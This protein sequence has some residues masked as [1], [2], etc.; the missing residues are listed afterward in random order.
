[1][2]VN[3]LP[4]NAAASVVALTFALALTGCGANVTEDP[5]A[6]GVNVQVTPGAPKVEPSRSLAFAAVVTGTISPAVTWSIQEGSAGGSISADGV[7]TA[8]GSTGV[9]RIVATSVADP[10]ATGTATVTVE[11]APTAPPPGTTWMTTANRTSGVAPLAVFFD[12]V[13]TV[14]EGF[15]SPYTWTTGVTQPA[16]LE[17]ATWVWDFGD[18]A[19]GTWTQTGNS[20]NAATGYTAAH[21][22][23][24]P[25]TYSVRLAVTGQDGV[26]RRYAQNVTVEPFTGTTYYVAAG[27]SDASDGL[28]PATPFRTFAKGVSMLTGPGRRLL[29]RRGDTFSTG[30]ASFT[31]TAS[32]PGI[33]GAYG[34]GERPVIDSSGTP[35][36]TNL[37]QFR[38]P[39]AKTTYIEDW[40]IMDLDFSGPGTATGGGIT[41]NVEWAARNF[42]FLR[43]RYRSMNVGLGWSDWT[44]IFQAP[45]DGMAV[46][47]CESA[48]AYQNGMYV[49]GRRLAM[50]GNDIHDVGYSHALRVWQAHK[51]VISNNRLWRPGGQRHA[52]KLHGNNKAVRVGGAYMPYGT[53]G[54]T[55][56]EPGRET[57]PETRWVTINDNLVKGG[58][59]SN[60]SISMGPQDSIS[61]ERVSHVVYERNHHL[62]GPA[63]MIDV[64]SSASQVMIRNNTF[65]ATLDGYYTGV[66][67][68][69]RGIEPVPTGYRVL[70]NTIY[71]GSANQDTV[72]FDFGAEVADATIRNNLLAFQ[73][74]GNVRASA[75]G[76]GPGWTFDHNLVTA[77][78][79][80][81]DA[82]AGDF[83]L[84]AGSPGV[85][86]GAALWDA[87]LDF[88]GQARPLGAGPDLG[89]IES[90]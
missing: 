13:E 67:V 74:G 9:F 8:P 2:F 62:G 33:I 45:R 5:V 55:A 89:A 58:D 52:L 81:A 75:G 14:P 87:S 64:E 51:A 10:N 43:N 22:F 56:V 77:T 66:F 53:P 78:P 3:R 26:T 36:G 72:G 30:G 16:D 83:T 85:D 50:L 41:F 17:G 70:H 54:G 60:W 29:F 57:C 25:G 27:G 84:L 79:A 47:E 90:R 19:A 38:G 35:A 23:E 40:R 20:R 28:S 68:H 1:M 46:V 88:L 34:T 6:Q 7:Y 31:V 39:G 32:G 59:L 65:D 61:D 73:A 21:V 37:L 42:L 18:A 69:R 12:A 44:P 63:T 49:G 15:A 80:F 4:V 86:A 24:Q 71:K 48:A 82:A 76:G 11:T